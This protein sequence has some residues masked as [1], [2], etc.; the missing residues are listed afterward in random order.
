MDREHLA[1]TTYFDKKFKCDAVRV[2]PGEYYISTK[3]TLLMTV[4]GSCVSACIWDK[5][6]GIGGLNHFML[7]GKASLDFNKSAR[8]G[9]YAMEILI[10]HIIQLGGKREDLVAKVFGGGKVMHSFTSLD[11]GKD[12]S[13]FIV[14]Y[15]RNESLPIIASDLG[16]I[17]PRKIC[18]FPQTGKVMV[19]KLTDTYDHEIEKQEDRYFSKVNKTDIEGEI[20]LFD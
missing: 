1:T 5:K 4:L 15:L 18:F 20:E 17:Y 3:N 16:D 14:D 2:L 10:N 19:R 6:R 13:T 8:Y 9:N 7:P 11:I 12:N